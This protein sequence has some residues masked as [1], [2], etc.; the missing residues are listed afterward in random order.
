MYVLRSIEARSRHHCCYG[1]PISVKDSEGVFIFVL[2]TWHAERMRSIILSS[3]VCLAL[4]HFSTLSHRQHGYQRR[5]IRYKRFA[6][7]FST[8]LPDTF[9]ILRRIKRDVII[10]VCRS[11]CK[12]LVILVGFY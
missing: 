11:L 4:P 1:N 10:N 8:A 6:S 2:A 7:I 5:V 12:I 3:V 9:L